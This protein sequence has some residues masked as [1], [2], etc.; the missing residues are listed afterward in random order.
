MPEGIIASLLRTSRPSYALGLGVSVACVVVESALIYLIKDY[1]PPTAFGVVYLLGVLLVSTIWGLGLAM[2][3]AL[4]SAAVYHFL[5]LWPVN[6]A[7]E[8]I[9]LPIFFIVGVLAGSITGVARA[10]AAE[11]HARQA[12]ADLAA[13]QAHLLLR[14][15]D[16]RS[17]L[18]EASERLARALELP[19]ATVIPEELVPGEGRTVFPLREGSTVLGTLVLPP[20]VPPSTLRRLRRRIVPALE[21]LVAAARE[22]EAIV[23]AL[24]ASRDDL[25]RIAEV[26]GA[27]RR[28]ATLVAQGISPEEIFQAVAG[29]IGRIVGAEYIAVT[30]FEPDAQ[31]TLVGSWR[32]GRTPPALRLGSRW[33]VGQGT[34]PDLVS[35]TGRPARVVL[36]D[37]GIAGGISRWARSQGLKCATGCPVMVQG[38]LWGTV[39]AFS[40]SAQSDP[41]EAE[42]RMMDFTEL[43]ATAVANADSLAELAASRARVV[44]ATDETRRRIERD[45]HDGTQ[46][47]LVSVALELRTAALAVPP[48]CGDLRRRLDHAV[49]G[50]GDVVENLR[51][52]SRGLHPA[53]L[54]MGGIEPA[55]RTL[56]RRSSVPVELDID[57]VRRLPERVEVAI[58]FIVSEALT[59]VAKHAHAS[60]AGVRLRVL[61][62]MAELAIHDDGAGGGDPRQGSG[63]IGLKDRVEA[64][65]GALEITSPIGGGT[66]LRARIPA[67][68]D[69]EPP[70]GRRAGP[71]L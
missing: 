10:S 53:I 34:V 63:L 49:N 31:V 7:T 24:E 47:H 13:E 66:C 2:A 1:V 44:A 22:R 50:L 40:A 58:Y 68:S 15:G 36:S 35:R 16:L 4:L 70:A 8:L 56:A 14:A 29:E 18:P 20:G 6:D 64:L 48:G 52:I 5:Y 57:G 69:W 61:D 39:I 19:Y 25:R 27:L 65:G 37:P 21:S 42:D 23:N 30:R 62:G 45:L 60:V 26:Q 59:N 32:G 46:Q 9:I 54:S 33:G 28:V 17:A 38:H 55:L 51:E 41:E 67:A 3:T 12:E 43:V 71:M 11:A